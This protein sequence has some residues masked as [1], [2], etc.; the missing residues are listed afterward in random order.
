MD[1]SPIT[2]LVAACALIA[3]C[4][5]QPAVTFVANGS[6]FNVISLTD[7]QDECETG[8]DEAA[9]GHRSLPRRAHVARVVEATGNMPD[10]GRSRIFG[11]PDC[12]PGGDGIVGRSDG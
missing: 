4:E 9:A 1:T 8:L 3:A 11:L 6:E 12:L 5:S 10:R 2:G 7:E